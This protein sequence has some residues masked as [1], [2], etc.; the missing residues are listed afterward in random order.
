MSEYIQKLGY[1]LFPVIKESG[2]GCK[3]VFEIGLSVLCMTALI[4]LALLVAKKR[5]AEKTQRTVAN[6][7]IFAFSLIAYWDLTRIIYLMKLYIGVG[8]TIAIV[9]AFL[10]LAL[11]FCLRYDRKKRN[12]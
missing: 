1:L 7:A 12:D 10:G 8:S 5:S 9:G 4:A 11:F 3:A 2:R 6:V